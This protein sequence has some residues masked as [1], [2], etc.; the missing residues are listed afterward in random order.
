MRF[1][2]ASIVQFILGFFLLLVLCAFAVTLSGCRTAGPQITLTN[3][4]GA[5]IH[6]PGSTDAA[7]G[8]TIPVKAL[9]DNALS[10]AQNGDPTATVEDKSRLEA[11]APGNLSA[12]AKAA[13]TKADKSAAAAAALRQAADDAA[14]TEP[15]KLPPASTVPTASTASTSQDPPPPGGVTGTRE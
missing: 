15:D 13:K 2:P 3:C 10:A 5:T 12:A 1:S 7:Q 9:A 8:K 6:V 11:S 14:K 4:P